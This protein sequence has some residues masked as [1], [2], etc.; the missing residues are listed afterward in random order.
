MLSI[1]IPCHNEAEVLPQLFA[2]LQAL[3]PDWDLAYEIILIDDGSGD[4]TWELIRR[5]HREDPRW[6]GLRLA[7]NFGQQ[8]AIGAGLGLARG[9]AVVILDADLQDPPELIADFLSLWQSGWQVVY[10]VRVERPESW[11]KQVCYRGFYRLLQVFASTAIPLDAGD[12]CLLDR[13]VVSALRR[14]RE[15]R[16]FW[17]GLRAWVGFR[18]IGVPYSRHS[19]QAGQ[20]QY[21]LGRLVRLALDGFDSMT[22]MQAHLAFLAAGT[23]AMVLIGGLLAGNSWLLPSITAALLA[24][25]LCLGL[26]IRSQAR[27]Q[28]ELRRR[29]RWVIADQ[30]GVA[31]FGRKRPHRLAA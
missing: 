2:R 23:A 4:D 3:A 27:L 12:F 8:A 17:R 20:S 1:I 5:F 9:Q 10:G 22:P 21:T 29:P 18:Q 31:A 16:P 26:V 7:R 19:R 24:Q 6:K 28:D 11:W 14:C 30:I 13:R 25:V 15:Q